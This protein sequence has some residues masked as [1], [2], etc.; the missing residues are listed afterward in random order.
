[1]STASA[2]L[3]PALEDITS[4][5]TS[6]FDGLDEEGPHMSLDE[7]AGGDEAGAADEAEDEMVAGEGEESE[8]AAEQEAGEENG[9]VN[10]PIATLQA[11][12]SQGGADDLDIGGVD[13]S[14]LG[15]EGMQLGE[16]EDLFA[17]I[18]RDN[19]ILA[20]KRAIVA[21][22][23]Q[24]IEDSK[25][26]LAKMAAIIKENEHE[27][28]KNENALKASS[29]SMVEMVK[30]YEA[31]IIAD[32][33]DNGVDADDEDD[34][35]GEA[36]KEEGEDAEGE[37]EAA[38]EEKKIAEKEEVR[39]EKIEEEAKKEA[40]EEKFRSVRQRLRTQHRN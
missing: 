8:T 29:R 5:D 34:E 14:Q 26:G 12:A 11:L 13:I 4:L 30:K 18:S 24:A 23:R 25:D 1:M 3:D 2:K 39:E 20:A 36:K 16:A 15:T 33:A 7:A 37:E 21:R 35:D 22:Q 17:E 31:K 28:A 6:V 32:V 10:D 40:A 38:K 19:T 27:L 9:D